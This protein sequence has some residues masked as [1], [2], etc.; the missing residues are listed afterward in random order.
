MRLVRNLI[1]FFGGVL[2]ICMVAR[3]MGAELEPPQVSF[4]VVQC[5][6]VVAIWVITHDGKLMRMDATNA[7]KD[8]EAYNAFLKWLGTSQQDLYEIPCGTKAAG[9]KPHSKTLT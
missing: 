5:G 6:D 9:G 4:G 3:A 2:A 1:A 7:P 8:P